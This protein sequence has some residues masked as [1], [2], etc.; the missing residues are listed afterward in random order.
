M[1]SSGVRGMALIAAVALAVAACGGTSTL[2]GEEEP[3]TTAASTTSSATLPPTTQPAPSTTTKPPPPPTT[4]A[5]TT[6]T[7]AAPTTTTTTTS[8]T[9]TTMQST[10]YL[11]ADGTAPRPGSDGADGSGC[12]P[13]DLVVI[14]PGVWFGYAVSLSATQVQFDMGCWYSGAEADAVAASRGDTAPNG[15]YIVN[16]NPLVYTMPAATAIG[17]PMLNNG[18]IGGPVTMATFAANPGPSNLT[19]SPYPVWVFVNYGQITEIAI[20][21]IP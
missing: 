19:I 18:S 10:V 14:P 20:Q 12:A 7:T 2:T 16:D 17:Y 21:Y 15:F 6:P 9:T 13:A 3:A 5:P 1:R 11:Y 8:T 4:V